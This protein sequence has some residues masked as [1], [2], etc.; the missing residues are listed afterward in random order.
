MTRHLPWKKHLPLILQCKRF[1][2]HQV[3]LD[4]S[5]IYS[6]AR[7][8][9]RILLTH[10]RFPLAL[11]SRSLGADQARDA[12]LQAASIRDP[13]VGAA[14]SGG[15]LEVSLGS[16][17]PRQNL[18]APLVTVSMPLLLP[19]TCFQLI[20]SKE[21]RRVRGRDGG[22][23]RDADAPGSWFSRRKQAQMLLL[24]A[25]R[26]SLVPQVNTS[27]LLTLHRVS[28]ALLAF[29]GR[30]PPVSFTLVPRRPHLL[31]SSGRQNGVLVPPESSE[32]DDA[33]DV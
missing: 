15:E 5:S 22:K 11:S 9:L 19:F 27:L 3:R 28:H 7:V 18:Q 2:C 20:F 4:D 25:D 6:S 8:P 33:G 16:E 23:A 14:R 17:D 32:G 26:A 21:R 29:E 12:G 1:P 13:R 24:S 31:H 30:L 10:P